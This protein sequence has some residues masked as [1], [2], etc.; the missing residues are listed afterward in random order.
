MPPPLGFKG[1]RDM[2]RRNAV[3]KILRM[4]LV[5]DNNGFVYFNELLFRSMKRLDFNFI[6]FRVY[7]EE[8]VKNITLA[9]Q[10]LSVLKKLEKLR[11]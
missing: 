7:G 1:M 9:Q 6:I 5:S 2:N 4:D 10:E 3:V 11:K 8:N